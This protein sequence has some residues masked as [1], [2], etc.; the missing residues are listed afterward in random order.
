MQ[1]VSPSANSERQG[2]G[3]VRGRQQCEL[4]GVD[5]EE[6][7]QAI[8][9]EEQKEG[10]PE[11]GEGEAEEGQPPKPL[12]QPQLPS[13]KVIELHELTHCPYR[14]WCVHCRKSR[15]QA[16]GHYG[17]TEEEEKEAKEKAMTT[18]FLIIH[19]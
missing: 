10:P 7:E 8:A 15:G 16:A 2:S 19:F 3:E 6:G 11:E 4:C 1:P 5:I 13:K 18:W 17:K 12:R 14:S 9:E